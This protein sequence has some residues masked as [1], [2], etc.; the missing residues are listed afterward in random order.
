MTTPEQSSAIQFWDRVARK[1][2]ARPIGNSDA[3][4]KTLDI[5]R[6]HLKPTDSVL[7]IGC[8]TGSTALLLAPD[9]AQYLASDPAPQMVAIG[10]EKALQAQISGLRNAQGALGDPALG[11]GPYDAVLAYNLLH[12]LPDIPGDLAKIHALLAP[13]G[14]FLSKTGC[15]SGW[16]NIFRPIVGILRLFGKAP[17]INF[18]SV[19]KLEQSIRQAGF[20]IIDACEPSGSP[21]GRLVVARKI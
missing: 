11:T 10:R 4:E 2:A 14:V 12:L 13:G 1:Y 15:I 8:G 21:L 20:D 6:S 18:I 3:Y 19:A 17:A 7:E 9:V 5:T 16:R